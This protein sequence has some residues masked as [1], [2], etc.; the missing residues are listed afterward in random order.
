MA[1]WASCAAIAGALIQIGYD[2]L[3]C[4]YRY[5]TISA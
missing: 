1:R 2:L 3:A 5:P 4:V